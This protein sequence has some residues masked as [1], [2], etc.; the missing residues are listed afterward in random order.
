[1]DEM[2]H[3]MSDVCLPR[4]PFKNKADRCSIISIC[5][6]FELLERRLR[7]VSAVVSGFIWVSRKVSFVKR[8]LLF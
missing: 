3:V 2:C 7:I 1:M 8:V 5:Y 6:S 4:L